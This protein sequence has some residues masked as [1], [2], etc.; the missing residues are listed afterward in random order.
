MKAVAD[1]LAEASAEWLHRE[2]RMI[3]WGY[4]ANE[5][6]KNED[7]IQE[8]Y[9]GIRPAPG[10]AACPDHSEKAMIWSILEVEEKIGI[11]LTENYAMFPTASVSGYYFGYPDISYFGVGK[12]GE[13]QVAAIAKAKNMD[14]MQVRKF[15]RP[16]LD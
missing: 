16:N 12:I 14:E 11:T 5:T 10:Y 7:L 9:R 4:D 1:R 6:L 13:D 8:K 15:L 2:V 3:Q